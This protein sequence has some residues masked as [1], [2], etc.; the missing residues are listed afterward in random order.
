[1]K[2]NPLLKILVIPIIILAVFLGIKA[3]GNKTAAEG[4]S[5]GAPTLTAEQAKAMGVD[6]DTPSDTLRTMVAEGRQL[7]DQVNQVLSD[8]KA[9]KQENE[10]LKLKLGTIDQTV[11]QRLQGV[12]DQM[13]AESQKQ[14]QSLT[15]ELQRQ[16][17]N[18]SQMS[19]PGANDM[20]IGL[21]ISAGDGVDVKKPSDSSEIIWISP[22]DATAVD[23]TGKPIAAGSNLQPSGFNFPSSFG[24]SVDRGQK[25]LSSG[26]ERVSDSMSPNGQQ[27]SRKKVRKVY[28]LPQNSTLMGSVAMSALIGRVPVDGTVNDPYPFKVL[29]GPDN[30]TA[31]GIDLPDVAGA[32]ASGT[33]SGDW[34]LSC[35]RGQ[36]RSMTFVFTDGTIRTLPAPSKDGQQNNS[37]QNQNQASA[38]QP[39]PVQGGMGWISDPYGIP[40]ISGERRSNAAQ[41]IGS[42]ALI[43]AAGAGAAS[44]IKSDNTT[45]SYVSTSGSTLGTSG[46]SGNQAMGQIL[47]SGV[48]DISAWVNKLYGQAFAAVYVEP[49]A[50]V[51]LHLDQ[52]LDIDY[53]IKGRKVNYGTGARH[54]AANLD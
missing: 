41:Y 40:C 30:L 28:T 16:F 5:A 51:V 17:T 8:N 27:E 10:T 46:V 32:V 54:A 13:K 49:G 38:G 47:N 53:E 18:L 44:L 34:T 36:I 7:K 6:G 4:G 37:N 29:I 12:R 3:F 52:E 48:S 45:S 39:Q 31:N 23:S 26:A 1:M 25:A 14:Q 22:Q 20:P 2:G 24:D 50:K 15:D 11:E 9:V 33:A 21:G 19:K 42:Q 35:V 43:T